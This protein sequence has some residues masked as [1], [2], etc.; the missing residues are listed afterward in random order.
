MHRQV[1]ECITVSAIPVT[2]YAR[3]FPP[4]LSSFE[5]VE[6]LGLIEVFG[7]FQYLFGLL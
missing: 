4:S 2:V 6:F 1:E 3:H 7:S 5:L